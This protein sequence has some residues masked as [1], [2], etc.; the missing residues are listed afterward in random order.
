MWMNL[1]LCVT[2]TVNP[3]L[4]LVIPNDELC[5]G[6]NYTK[7]VQATGGTPGYTYSWSGGLGSGSQKLTTCSKWNLY[8]YCYG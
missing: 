6:A 2:L 8:S 1:A 5:A 7:T 4:N 3:Q